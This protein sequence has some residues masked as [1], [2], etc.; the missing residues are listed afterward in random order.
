LALQLARALV[1]ATLQ[2]SRAAAELG[3]A[4]LDLLQHRVEARAERRE[5]SAPPP[6]GRRSA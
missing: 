6:M 5:L 3:I 4:S 2:A 1:D